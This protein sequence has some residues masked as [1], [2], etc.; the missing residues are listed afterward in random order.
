MKILILILLTSFNLIAQSN[1][2][3]SDTDHTPETL[4]YKRL[5][6]SVG[7]SI[8][9]ADLK[10]ID[11]FTVE[12]SSIRSKIVRFNPFAG[13]NLT[14]A[15]VP[16][17]RGTSTGV[18][19]GN[20]ID[21]N[22][23]TTAF[24][25]GDYTRTGGLGNAGNTTAYLRTGIISSA[26]SALG[27]NSIALGIWLLNDWGP[28]GRVS[29]GCTDG[30]RVALIFPRYTGDI[31]RAIINRGSTTGGVTNTNAVGL[32]IGSRTTSTEVKQYKNA[33]SVYTHA[34]VSSGETTTEFWVMAYNNNGAIQYPEIRKSTGYI[35]A[36]GLTTAEIVILY[37]AWN[38]L[39]TAFGR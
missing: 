14:T 33:D 29:I 2:L 36:S 22:S 27:Q 20:A 6:D 26:I 9:E 16:L 13:N 7:G 38:K 1:L 21:V 37:N 18:V 35:I 17:Y 15:C 24:V 3:F 23:G 31:F 10:A 25:S 4:E 19:Y 12:I 8:S 5:I 28:I 30:T 34:Q 39:K 32:W 11:V